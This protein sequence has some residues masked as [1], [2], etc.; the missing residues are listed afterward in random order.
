VRYVLAK[1]REAFERKAYRIY[2]SDSLRAL[3]GNE[4]N[5]HYTDI[6]D[7]T[8]VNKE[9]VDKKAEAIKE[10]IKNKLKGGG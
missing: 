8:V 4:E 6:I 7:R 10:R 3:I 2:I 5:A 9:E 1:E